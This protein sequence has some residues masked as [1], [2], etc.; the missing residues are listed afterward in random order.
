MDF[1]LPI[2]DTP[3]VVNFIS[4]PESRTLGEEKARQEDRTDV[5]NR[6]P[7]DAALQKALEIARTELARRRRGLGNL[8]QE[9]ETVIEDLLFRTVNRVSKLAGRI[10]ESRSAFP[11]G[12]NGAHPT[13]TWQQALVGALIS[14]GP[15]GRS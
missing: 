14:D 12:F 7:G 13:P 3:G 6:Q 4:A 15:I 8:T 11:L 5:V 1:G 10:L 2:T 9:Q